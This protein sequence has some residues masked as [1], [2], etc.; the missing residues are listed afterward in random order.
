MRNQRSSNKQGIAGGQKTPPYSKC[1]GGQFSI[2]KLTFVEKNLEGCQNS[3][4]KGVV[5]A[6]KR[7]A[8]L[9]NYYLGSRLMQTSDVDIVDYYYYHYI[10]VQ[11]RIC[12]CVCVKVG[13]VSPCK[14]M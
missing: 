5:R 14:V 2:R 6:S 3:L 8:L 7:K 1:E 11:G 10:Q 12:V 13:N 4:P 9:A